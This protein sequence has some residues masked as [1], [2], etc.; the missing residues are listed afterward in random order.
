MDALLS[1]GPHMTISVSRKCVSGVWYMNLRHSIWSKST[2]RLLVAGLLASTTMLPHA[3]AQTANSTASTAPQ[4]TPA[5]P[6]ANTAIPSDAATG[7]HALMDAEYRWQTEDQGGT[8][9]DQGDYAATVRLPSVTPASQA[10]RVKHWQATLAALNAIATTDLSDD[11]QINAAVLRTL[12]DASLANAKYKSWEMPLNS[13]STFWTY[14]DTRGGLLTVKDYGNYIAKMRDIPRFFDENIANMRSGLKRGFSAPRI[15]LEG[16][17]SSIA[18]FITKDAASNAFYAAFANMPS[19]IPAAEQ[20]RLRAA[21]QAVIENSVIP[22]YAKLLQFYRADYLPK[23][24]Q[25][26]AV[27]A[28]PD[29]K[30]YYAAQIKEYTTLDLTADQIHQIG[31]KEVARIQADM[32]QVMIDSGFKGSFSEFIEFLRT[33]PQFYAKTPDELMGVSAYVAKRVDGKLSEIFGQLPRRRFTILPVPDALAPFYTAG[34]GGLEACWMNTH[35]LP[36]RPLYNIPALT[37]HECAPGHS[38]QAAIAEERRD[39]PKL[40]RNT[41][42]SGFGEG[43]GLY[44]EWLGISMGIYRTPYEHFGRLSYE[45]W[46]AARL[47]IDTGVHE[48]G[49]SRDQAIAYLADH[50]ALSRHEVETEVDRYISW[51]GQAL[52]Y[53]LGEMTIRRLRGEAEAALGEKFDQRKFHDLILSLG[54]VPLPVLEARISKFIAK[55]GEA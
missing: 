7:L 24:R 50:T 37:L 5:T 34:R 48:K 4:T 31:L 39:G 52:A 46:R 49:W 35:S 45:M 54:S 51:P 14:L 15:T 23:T 9:D 29:G 40:R 20:A 43:W 47:V 19:N 42:F 21:G 33:D 6:S 10:D 28:M 25:S 12:L 13:D 18:S 26:I 3:A 27:D 41:Y 16:R 8:L 53:K 2:P 38:L 22:A 30:A 17:D 1:F 11:D 36:S 32:N 44:T 55:G